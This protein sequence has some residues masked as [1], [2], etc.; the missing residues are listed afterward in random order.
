MKLLISSV[1]AISL[2]STVLLNAV[3]GCASN[4]EVELAGE[5]QDSFTSALE[6][7]KNGNTLIVRGA[8]LVTKSAKVSAKDLTIR[9][10]PCDGENGT[11][12]IDMGQENS[13]KRTS[14]TTKDVAS[15]VF[16]NENELTLKDLTF[17][18]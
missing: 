12:L 2:S 10:E 18:R 9:G 8:T 14:L 15:I 7:A 16:E 11:I 3:N 17:R 6:N 4:C 5:C 13:D 1:L